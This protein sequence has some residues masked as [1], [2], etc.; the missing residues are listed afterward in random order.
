MGEHEPQWLQVFS[1]PHRAPVADAAFVMTALDIPHEVTQEAYRWL[2]WV[3]SENAARAHAELNAYW[4]ENQVVAQRPPRSPAIDSGLLGVLGFLLVIWSLPW[5]Q[6]SY[7]GPWLEQG[8]MAAALVIQGE[9]W[10]TLTALT[11]HADLGHIASNSAFGA[12]FGG[13]LGR[14]LGSGVAWLLA[15]VAA[16][17]ANTVN[18]LVQPAAFLSI[19]ASTATFAALG[20]LATVVWRRGYYRNLDWRRSV[21]PLF[22][23]IA[24]FSFTGI[25]DLNT[26]VLAHLFGGLSGALIGLTAARLPVHWLGPR[27]QLAAGATALICLLIAWQLALSTPMPEAVA[28]HG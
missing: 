28:M 13:L 2:L 19:G 15:L 20:L 25:G 27:V 16:G 22:A 4:A 8:R 26:D 17:I 6:S 21:A 18:A 10:R 1:H 11:L 24:M 12:L 14:Q 7:P 9:W 3:P 5:L 23:A